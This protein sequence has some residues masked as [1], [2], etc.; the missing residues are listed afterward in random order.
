MNVYLV[1]VS[2]SQEPVEVMADRYVFNEGMLLF[3]KEGYGTPLAV[4]AATAWHCVREAT[5]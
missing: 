4:F 5:S 3:Y 2:F 1:F